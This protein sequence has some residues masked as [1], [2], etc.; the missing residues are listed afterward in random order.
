VSVDPTARRIL[1]LVAC[2]SVAAAVLRPGR[3]PSDILE[4]T[5]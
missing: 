4:I 1:A 2:G 5:T 3:A